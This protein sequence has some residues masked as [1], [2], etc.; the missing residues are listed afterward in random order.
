MVIPYK[1]DRC[2]TDEKEVPLKSGTIFIIS[3]YIIDS[4]NHTLF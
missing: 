4:N 2:I 1:P 3:M